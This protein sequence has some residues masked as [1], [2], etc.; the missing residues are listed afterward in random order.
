MESVRYYVNDVMHARAWL[1]MSYKT[2]TIATELRL[3]IIIIRA[4]ST[5]IM[6]HYCLVLCTTVCPSGL[7][8]EHAP[9]RAATELNAALVASALVQELPEGLQ[10]GLGGALAEEELLKALWRRGGEGR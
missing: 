6:V 1:V 3:T 10:D 2:S 5:Y 7:L 9:E 4:R 8:C